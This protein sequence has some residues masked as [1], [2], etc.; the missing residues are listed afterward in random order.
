[1]LTRNSDILTLV[2]RLSEHYRLNVASQYLR[3][4]FFRL[5]VSRQD[6]DHIETVAEKHVLYRQQGWHLDELYACLL[7]LARFIHKARRQIVPDAR[8]VALGNLRENGPDKKIKAEMSAANFGSNLGLMA[9]MVLELF[10]RCKDE[11]ASLAPGV[12][13]AWKK[14]PAMSQLSELLAP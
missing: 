3:P 14:D 5:D 1:M 13:P 9:S 10:Q 12:V 2:D 4:A 8:S 6:W 11:E 7:S